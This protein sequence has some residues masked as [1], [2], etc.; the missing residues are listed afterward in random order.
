MK[1]AHE[2][3]LQDVLITVY[4]QNGLSDAFAEQ[5][6]ISAYREVVGDLISKLSRK[7]MLQKDTLH[8]QL[9]SAALRQEM[10]LR[11]TTLVEKIAE[12]TSTPI[13]K[14]IVFY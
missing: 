10:S 12:K 5:E 13:V 4:R 6:A 9:S 11:K 3:T 8:V 14:D 7:V 1:Q 2:Y